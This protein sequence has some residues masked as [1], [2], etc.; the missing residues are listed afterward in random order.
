VNATDPHFYVL[1]VFR[2]TKRKSKEQWR[3]EAN[4]HVAVRTS[5]DLTKDDGI[6]KF[7][8]CFSQ[9]QAFSILLEYASMGNLEQLFRAMSP[10]TDMKDILYL[11]K[12]YLRLIRTLHC[13]R[14]M[15]YLDG[16]KYQM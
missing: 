3:K 16:S 9:G 13:L 15:E 8:G 12:S 14:R 11:W 1:K 6:V 10:P 7:H 5:N 2:P 4:A